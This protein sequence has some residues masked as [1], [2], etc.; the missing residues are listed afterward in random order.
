LSIAI[1]HDMA[2]HMKTTVQIPDPL[3]TRAKAVARETGT[4]LA[5]LV[6]QGLRRVVEERS[7]KRRG[8]KL[9]NVSVK[10]QGL[11]PEYA[12]GWDAVRAAVYESRGG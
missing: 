4:T 6:E 9:R 12:S 2:S 8:F 11:S 1:F 10:G 3:L 5:A 7:R